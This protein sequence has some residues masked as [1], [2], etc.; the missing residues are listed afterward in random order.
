M[1]RTSNG[2]FFHEGDVEVDASDREASH[3]G[4]CHPRY[5]SPADMQNIGEP[6]HAGHGDC[7][8]ADVNDE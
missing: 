3:G 6:C 5:P 4:K 8:E 1:R 7:H 2:C